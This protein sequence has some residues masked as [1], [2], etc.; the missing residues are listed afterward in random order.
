MYVFI[1]KLKMFWNVV[2]MFALFVCKLKLS[3]ENLIRL[4]QN[5]YKCKI[6]RKSCKK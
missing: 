3:F 6:K 5:E 1:I 4:L 2:F